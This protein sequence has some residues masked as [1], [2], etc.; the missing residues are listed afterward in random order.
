MKDKVIGL[1]TKTRID[2]TKNLLSKV[3]FWIFTEI[4]EN[5]LTCLKRLIQ[6][7]FAQGDWQFKFHSSQRIIPSPRF[8]LHSVSNKKWPLKKV[9]IQEIYLSC[10]AP[11]FMQLNICLPSRRL[12]LLMSAGWSP[13]SSLSSSSSSS[14]SSLCWSKSRKMSVFPVIKA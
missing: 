1:R 9:I 5:I 13:A 6:I 7:I 10:V 12:A 11:P 2:C 8:D 3:A 14:S 4:A